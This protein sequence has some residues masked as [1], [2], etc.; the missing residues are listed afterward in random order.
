MMSRCVCSLTDVL[1]AIVTASAYHLSSSHLKYIEQ[2]RLQRFI[3]SSLVFDYRDIMHCA[4]I[5]STIR[6]NIQV[7]GKD[8]LLAGQPC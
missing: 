1:T 8:E 2:A 6:S 5:D 4:E 3:L 7:I